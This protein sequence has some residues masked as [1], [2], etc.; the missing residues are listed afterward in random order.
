MKY[1]NLIFKL[2]SKSFVINPWI[3]RCYS[4]NNLDSLSLLTV[5]K[6]VSQ[7]RYPMSLK[8]V[9]RNTKR[10][11]SQMTTNYLQISRI[12]DAPQTQTIKT[13][14]RC[15]N[16]RDAKPRARRNR[17]INNNKIQLNNRLK[18]S[19]KKKSCLGGGIKI[20][21]PKEA[22]PMISI[23]WKGCAVMKAGLLPRVSTRLARAI[24]K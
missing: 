19:I 13:R 1:S 15:Q 21:D 11:I 5:H 16:W 23:K 7:I 4:R 12:P 22:V 14:R 2:E 9:I 20:A 24:N 8:N 6:N 18:I 10:Y 3:N 17:L